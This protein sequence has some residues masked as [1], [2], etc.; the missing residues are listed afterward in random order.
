MK[1]DKSFE[2]CKLFTLEN[3]MAEVE[4]KF[5]MCFLMDDREPEITSIF[6]F[7]WTH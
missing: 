6:N 7:H 2:A 3:S 4:W 1:Y 5:C